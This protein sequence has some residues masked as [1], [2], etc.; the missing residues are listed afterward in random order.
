MTQ[1]NDLKLQLK[2]L[3][4]SDRAHIA[5]FL[6]KTLDG[7]DEEDGVKEAWDAEIQ[8]RVAEIESGKAIGIPLEQV[9]A[10]LDKEF[11]CRR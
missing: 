7:D 4:Q 9:L 5:C 2:T 11:P 6:L 1:V 8:R 10:E 3:S